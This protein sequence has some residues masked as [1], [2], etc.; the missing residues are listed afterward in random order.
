LTEL[1]P[2]AEVY[3]TGLVLQKHLAVSQGEMVEGGK[4]VLLLP[5]QSGETMEIA[6]I[7][8]C[9]WTLCQSLKLI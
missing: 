9:P 8:V 5:K 4:K 1:C 2:A 7:R 6:V 3:L